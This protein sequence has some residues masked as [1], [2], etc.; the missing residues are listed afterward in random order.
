M[1]FSGF[2]LGAS[3]ISFGI[4]GVSFG[5]TSS[6]GIPASETLAVSWFTRTLP[7]TDAQVLAAAGPPPRFHK[8]Y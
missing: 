2:A 6:V 8:K 4:A 3:I 5:Q 7:T 1:R